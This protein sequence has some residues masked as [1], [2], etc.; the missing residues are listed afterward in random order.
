MPSPAAQ[1]RARSGSPALLRDH[2]EGAAAAPAGQDA[3]GQGAAPLPEGWLGL[4]VG[5]TA[6]LIAAKSGWLLPMPRQQGR[7]LLQGGFA[8]HA[9]DRVAGDECWVRLA[10]DPDRL[11]TAPVGASGHEDGTCASAVPAGAGRL[12]WVA[13]IPLSAV[14]AVEVD[15]RMHPG[16]LRMLIR[17]GLK[18]SLP[19]DVAAANPRASV[20]LPC[21]AQRG[22][23]RLPAELNE[24]QGAMSAAVWAAWDALPEDR[25]RRDAVLSAM[26]GEGESLSPTA[27]WLRP[28]WLAKEV[29]ARPSPERALWSNAP[30]VLRSSWRADAALERVGHHMEAA[31]DG[32]RGREWTAWARAVLSGEV[33]VFE[34]ELVPAAS[35]PGLAVMVALLKN[36]LEGLG[37]FVREWGG[38]GTL[39]KPGSPWA[40]AVLGAAVLLGWGK[41]FSLISA[42][43]R[44]DAMRREAVAR[45]AMAASWDQPGEPPAPAGRAAAR[46]GNPQRPRGPAGSPGP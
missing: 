45:L 31:G 24:V 1:D 41:G 34:H 4:E 21:E 5:E 20:T 7:P 46:P 26:A 2:A 10:L 9:E 30:H 19:E 25:A 33:T 11:W 36:D 35:G 27:P 38:D 6:L 28:P 8:R 3:A 16:N 12:D 37:Q 18:L 43:L 22:G 15:E 32:G 39:F 17:H 40:D 14:A 29:S 42:D 23:W 44:G 13:P